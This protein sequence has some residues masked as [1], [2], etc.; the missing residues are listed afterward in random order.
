MRPAKSQYS[1]AQKAGLSLRELADVVFSDRHCK[2]DLAVLLKTYIDDS[3]DERQEQVVV[4][5]A[6]T[7]TF[8]QWSKLKRDWRRRLLRDEI[9]YFRSTEYYSLTGQFIRYRD[10]V[11]YPKPDGS[12]AASA[13]RDDL[14][15]I[16]RD[17]GIIGW[18]I[19][20]P[21]PVW[22]SFRAK[23]PAASQILTEPFEVALQLLFGSLAKQVTKELGAGH[24]LTF[25]A[26]EGPS[27]RR[28]E[29][30]YLGFKET[31]RGLDNI[32]GFTHLDDKVSPP[33]Q[34]ADMMASVSKELFLESI[35][36]G[37][38]PVPKHLKKVVKAVKAV[39][40]EYLKALL[41]N[42]KKRR[43]LT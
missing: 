14:E 34:A 20:I 27:A 9:E 42:E 4:A 5:G 32:Q 23:D 36:T 15:A 7:G 30:V 43:R 38:P 24:R 16:V 8:K 22:E 13:L 17:S 21:I 18:A 31:N 2:E 37:L 25:I 1:C 41:E 35:R 10:P 11:R 29:K 39:N 12:K 28:I 33:L 3:A 26:D 19:C 40:E 6:F